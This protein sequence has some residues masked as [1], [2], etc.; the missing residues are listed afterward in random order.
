MKKINGYIGIG[1][2]GEKGK[3]GKNG[4][5][6]YF[7]NTSFD[8][9]EEYLY[10]DS[11]FN[12]FLHTSDNN[13]LKIN[14]NLFDSHFIV[15]DK[16]IKISKNLI[17]QNNIFSDKQQKELLKDEYYL[18]LLNANTKGNF[19][20]LSIK[21]NE[22]NIILNYIKNK[23]AFELKGNLYF[24]NGNIFSCCFDCI[25]N[26]FDDFFQYDNNSWQLI[27]PSPLFIKNEDIKNKIRISLVNYIEK[28]FNGSIATPGAVGR[29][30]IYECIETINKN[31]GESILYNKNLKEYT[32]EIIDNNETIGYDTNLVATFIKIDIC[33]KDRIFRYMREIKKEQV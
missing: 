10:I 18:T 16:E 26:N 8:N 27:N 14:D 23:N 17:L 6:T 28:V 7:K 31:F 13:T 5:S 33:I 29:N 21:N 15:N 2:E 30:N 3:K 19:N 12:K 32:K 1:V 25:L 24:T 9:N 11:S 4:I 22:E 20:F